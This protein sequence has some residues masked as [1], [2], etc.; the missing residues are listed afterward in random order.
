MNIQKIKNK[1]RKIGYR[2]AKKI[3]DDGCVFSGGC[4]I[5]EILGEYYQ[6]K[7]D[8]DC[9]RELGTYSMSVKGVNN[10]FRYEDNNNY[11]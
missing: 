6:I 10:Y 1:A 2:L 4:E 11:L 9:P 3:S 8:V 5:V 7:V